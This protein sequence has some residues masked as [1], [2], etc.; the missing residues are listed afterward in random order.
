MEILKLYKATEAQLKQLTTIYSGFAYF[1]TDSGNL[2]LDINNERILVNRDTHEAAAAA[3]ESLSSSL[4]NYATNESVADAVRLAHEHS[5]KEI[6]D[7][8]TAAFTAEEK[9]K[10]QG[11]K[12]VDL[13]P[14]LTTAEAGDTFALKSTVEAIANSLSDYAKESDLEALIS[15]VAAI[16][17]WKNGLQNAEEV[18][19]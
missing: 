5:N 17:T 7:A 13:T 8:T 14:Y 2:Y 19:F 12:E 10:L 4:S 11:L 1:C 16:E 9:L 15:R 6:L 18:E 3:L